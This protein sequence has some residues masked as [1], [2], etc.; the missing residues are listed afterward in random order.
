MNKYVSKNGKACFE[1]WT[2]Q[3][4]KMAMLECFM[5]ALNHH[6]N[7]IN[8]FIF[9]NFENSKL[10][11]W[12]DKEFGCLIQEDKLNRQNSPNQ[13]M[14]NQ[15]QAEKIITLLAQR[16]QAIGSFDSHE[17]IDLYRKNFE[18]DYISMLVENDNDSNNTAF[19]RTNSQIARFLSANSRDLNIEESGTTDSVNDH[20]NKT[21]N[22]KW[23]F[24]ST[25]IP[26]I[27][28][29]I[30]G[31]FP[32]FSQDS[33]TQ[34]EFD[35]PSFKHITMYKVDT[36]YIRKDILSLQDFVNQ[37]CDK[38]NPLYT[39]L[40]D[41]LR[42]QSY[43]RIKKRYIREASNA[44]IEKMQKI[45]QQPKEDLVYNF[46]EI[47]HYNE[48]ENILTGEKSLC[49]NKDSLQP[50]FLRRTL[51][52][53]FDVSVFAGLIYL[54]PYFSNKH[55]YYSIDYKIPLLE[56]TKK[57]PFNQKEWDYIY[58][59]DRKKLVKG[60]EWVSDGSNSKINYARYVQKS[61]P[62]NI[63]YYVFDSH[64]EYAFI[65][66]DFPVPHTSDYDWIWGMY[67]LQGDLIRIQCLEYDMKEEIELAENLTCWN[68]YKN[69]AY[70]IASEDSLTKQC[71]EMI[72]NGKT[73]ELKS[74]LLTTQLTLALAGD[75]AS[76]FSSSYSE[77]MDI[78][79]RVQKE[80]AMATLNYANVINS[81]EMKKAEKYVE[82]L[83]R[84][85]YAKYRGRCIR[86]DDK[87]FYFSLVTSRGKAI[88]ILKVEYVNNGPFDFKK[89][90]TPVKICKNRQEFIS[91]P[92]HTLP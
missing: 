41:L 35:M 80:G 36:A 6:K 85:Q 50:P 51:D 53:D 88:C 63:S 18:H 75:I 13:S 69:N 45:I 20:G 42:K 76:T 14:I 19:Q 61:Y 44:L 23:N 56:F 25:V 46:E 17:F 8:K 71:V 82:Q 29:F 12:T 32:A 28:L 7:L 65:R 5:T 22:A 77:E 79:N 43:F 16:N 91:S 68:D 64:P 34:T 87:S 9:I 49:F 15:N 37:G 89:I 52:F 11:D 70:N 67:N 4:C 30:C 92:P 84:D 21:P 39:H 48:D 24:L 90:I 47:P 86:I 55:A 62:L 54:I 31:L 10:T 58:V 59:K 60:F 27:V 2:G 74:E 33:E 38:E 73:K 40:K 83:I 78:R 72:L 66:K 57:E 1:E 3:C 26:V 81:N